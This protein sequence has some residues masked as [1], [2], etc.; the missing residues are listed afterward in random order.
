M[1]TTRAV[2]RS[3]RSPLRVAQARATRGTIL[4]AAPELF[5]AAGYG[6]TSIDAIADAAGVSR[7][8]VFNVF[9]DKPTLLKSAY[10]VALVGDDEPVALPD[11]ADS[12]A[13]RAEPDPARYLERYAALIAELGGR[14]SGIYEAVRGAAG[15]DPEVRP[16]W[17]KILAERRVGAEHVVADTASKGPLRPGL[18][19]AAAADVVWILIDPGL[20]HLL[21]DRRGW[22]D[23]SFRNWLAG[24]LV[25]ELLGEE[26]PRQGGG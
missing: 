3:Y 20:H 12:K 15:T 23:E 25:R 4:A 1:T 2:K 11:R 26:R 24:Q 19:P 18:D 9:G 21:V 5:V 7:A 22:S 14:V 16:V 13:I 17:E 6:A 10:D 8:T